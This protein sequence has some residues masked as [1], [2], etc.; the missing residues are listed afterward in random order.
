M[1]QVADGAACLAQSLGRG[2][3]GM[4][5]GAESLQLDGL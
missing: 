1:Q 3:T 4:G 2:L 5:T